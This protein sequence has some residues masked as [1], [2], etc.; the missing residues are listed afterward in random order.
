ML[1]QSHEEQNASEIY[2][3]QTHADVENEMTQC[4]PYK[5]QAEALKWE[6]QMPTKRE[7]QLIKQ[8]KNE[9]ELSQDGMKSVG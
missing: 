7:Q 1:T 9:N 6:K 2:G 8:M 4:A 3:T 5:S